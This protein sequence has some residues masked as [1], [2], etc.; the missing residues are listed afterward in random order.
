[1]TTTAISVPVRRTQARRRAESDDR[2]LTAAADIIAAEG[3]VAL[4]LERVGERAG[5][6]RG[7]ASRKYGSKAGL[8][9]A[10][11][12]RTEACVRDQTDAALAGVTDPVARLICTT[13]R[14]SAV[15][16]FAV[17]A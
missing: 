4:T 3:Y 1:M 11:I 7:L 14:H 16:P 17:I 6:S 10:L 9:A 12:R 8:I 5:F 2:L 15:A 13:T